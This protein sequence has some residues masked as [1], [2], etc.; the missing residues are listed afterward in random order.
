[1]SNYGTYEGVE[2]LRQQAKEDL[3]GCIL[4]IL[5]HDLKKNIDKGVLLH[6]D[7]IFARNQLILKQK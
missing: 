7:S 2:E 1:M 5:N 3:D 4:A 6:P